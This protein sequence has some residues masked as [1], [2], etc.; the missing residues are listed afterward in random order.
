MQLQLM[1]LSVFILVPV[2]PVHTFISCISHCS[3]LPRSPGSSAP[4]VVQALSVASS[5]DEMIN[6]ISMIPLR[7]IYES[8]VLL[9]IHLGRIS[10]EQNRVSL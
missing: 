1:T 7:V 4:A 8:K 3:I 2:I 10:P 9:I 6:L 5:I